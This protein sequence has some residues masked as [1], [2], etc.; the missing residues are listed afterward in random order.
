[1][2][3]AVAGAVVND[4]VDVQGGVDVAFDVVQE[5]AEV[6][7]VVT[8]RFAYRDRFGEHLAG[9]DVEGGEQ[10]GGAVADV[11]EL[12]ASAR[13]GWAGWSRWVRLLAWIEVFS[14]TDNTNA[15]SGG[16]RYRPQTSRTRSQNSG[17]SRRL[18]Q[19][20][21]LVKSMSIDVKMRH[22]C[23]TDASIP[24]ARQRLGDVDVGPR[25]HRIG[26]IPFGSGDRRHLQPLVMAQ[27]PRSTATAPD[28]PTHPGDARGT[29][30]ATTRPDAGRCRRSHRSDATA[31]P[32]QHNRIT[33]A[34]RASRWV[35][36]CARA[37]RS[38]SRRSSSL[39]TNGST[40]T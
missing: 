17:S 31:P 22:T 38:N 26:R 23:E 28:R 25:R 10:R 9:M 19:P 8:P 1:M 40:R 14:S 4:D 30:A 11:L 27:P 15:C 24:S 12:A 20:R 2:S 7:R 16:S 35:E 5:G 39:I 36:V 13:P 6:D 34:R 3:G 21:T 33:R 18:S 37:R 32:R 29:G